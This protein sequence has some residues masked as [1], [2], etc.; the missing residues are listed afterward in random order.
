MESA[1]IV[2][3]TTLAFEDKESKYLFDSKEGDSHFSPANHMKEIKICV[4]AYLIFAREGTKSISFSSEQKKI[5]LLSTYDL[6][7]ES[8]QSTTIK[9][10]I[11]AA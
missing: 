5:K 7:K 11:D 2:N 4:S 9:E 8:T 1:R 3:S 10:K 6:R